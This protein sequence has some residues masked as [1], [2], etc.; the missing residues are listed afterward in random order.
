MLSFMMPTQEPGQGLVLFQR[1]GETVYQ[2]SYRKLFQILRFYIDRF[3]E[4]FGASSTVW[5]WEERLEALRKGRWKELTE[6]T[7]RSKS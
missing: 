1:D 4:R 2:C 3:G 6:E 7:L 5:Q